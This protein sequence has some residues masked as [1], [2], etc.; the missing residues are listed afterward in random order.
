MKKKK[1]LIDLY[2]LENPNCGF[3]QIA[4]NYARLF[5]EVQRSGREDFDIVFLLPFAFRKNHED[6]SAFKGV[7]C[8]MEETRLHHIFHAIPNW[9]P[10]VDVWHSI[11]QFCRRYPDRPSTRHIFTIHDYNFLFEDT[12]EQQK[13]FLEMMQQRIDRADAVTFISH[14]TEQ[15]VKEH[16]R[17]DGKLTRTI[18]NGVESLSDKPMSRPSF[19]V[20]DKPFF[21]AIG[22]FLPKKKFDVLLDMMKYL[23]DKNLFI[24]GQNDFP[25]GQQIVKRI[26]EE[27]ISN[28]IVPGSISNEE[29]TWLFA[30]CEAYLFPSIGE[31]FGLPAIEAMQFGKPVFASTYQSLPEIVGTHG[32]IWPSLEPELMAQTVK[33][34]LDD[35]YAQPENGRAAAAYAASFSYEKHVEAYLQL[36]RELLQTA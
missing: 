26:K 5:A 10:K 32:F 25:Y 36:Y 2:S 14:Y 21:F 34:H 18:Y 27:Q 15:L 16:S 7:K 35:F 6:L 31:G 22:Q 28:V 19:V 13:V 30:H 1:V 20:D 29:R 9:L 17:L 11:N 23:P 3:G 12:E 24:C 8:Y 4:V 33:E